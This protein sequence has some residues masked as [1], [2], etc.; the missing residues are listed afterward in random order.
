M[1]LSA[2]LV[3]PA[4][5]GR[6]RR[7][8]LAAAL[9]SA[10]LVV[11]VLLAGCV[12]PKNQAS[13][14]AAGTSTP[15]PSD[16]ATG[17]LAQFYG[18]QLDW[19][20]CA[21]G[22]CA[23]AQVP[24]DY[25]NPS[26]P[27]IGIALARLRATGGEPLG[28]L[29][30]NPGGPGVSGVDFLAS[31]A[32][33]V[34]PDVRLQY[35]LVAFDPRGVQRS[36]PVDCV[37]GPALDELLA[38]DADYS[39]DAGIQ[40]VI[41]MYGELGAGCAER[42]GDSLAH[43]DTVSATRDLDILRGALGDEKLSYLGYSYGTVLGSTYAAL[44]PAKVGR[45]VLDGAKPPTLTTTEVSQG[46]AV[47]FENALRAYIADCQAGP[48]CPMDGSV[49][50][51][52]EQIAGLLDRARSN[53]LSTGTARDLTAS[54][55][56]YGIAMPLY[57]QSYWPYL[58]QALTGALEN[59][60][61][62]M[63]LQLADQYFDREPDGTYSTNAMVAFFAI[64]CLDSRD[65]ADFEAMRA[66][67][68]QIE[69][70]APTVGVYFGYGATVCAQWPVPE[71]GG[72]PSYTA[73]GAAPILVVGTTGDPATPYAWAE[74]MADLLSSGVLLTYEG[75][76]HTAYGSSNECIAAAVDGY[77]LSGTVPADGTRC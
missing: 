27:S 67:A 22:E 12:A 68:A 48:G 3:A 34:S 25:A 72:L 14:P 30:V 36:S 76:G 35:D 45:L 16:E 18:Q 71:V 6:D 52:L 23:T 19:T 60:D 50:D 1:P 4:G 65:P 5:V 31:V 17:D 38:Y 53:P 37:D 47:G 55:A 63:L 44:F 64:N 57:S 28:S 59:N 11:V 21:E 51:G 66:E 33:T 10:A 54:L 15:A 13:A 32:S 40:T 8:R 26:G 29:L 49:D 42:T 46:Q 56:F 41:D 39:T 74:E 58:T 70:A 69:A 62:S 24:T 2:R 9:V 75:E 7:P 73:E 20:T 61:G 77:L 43:V